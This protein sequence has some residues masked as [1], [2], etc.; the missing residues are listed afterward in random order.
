MLSVLAQP[1]LMHLSVVRDLLSSEKYGST[2][3]MN[4]RA[5]LRRSAWHAEAQRRRGGGGVLCSWCQRNRRLGARVEPR[6][7]RVDTK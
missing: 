3:N 5:A 4:V 6:K 2:S 7:L 1:Y